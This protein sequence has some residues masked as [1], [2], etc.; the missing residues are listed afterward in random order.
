MIIILLLTYMLEGS[1]SCLEVNYMHL[2]LDEWG[3]IN[4]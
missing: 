4:A 1:H 3:V 2:V